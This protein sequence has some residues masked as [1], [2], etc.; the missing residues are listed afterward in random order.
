MEMYF[1]ST[2]GDISGLLPAKGKLAG[3]SIPYAP[4]P[5]EAVKRRKKEREGKLKGYIYRCAP[6]RTRETGERGSLNNA[7]RSEEPLA[8][9]GREEYI[10]E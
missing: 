4:T 3:Q 6:L 8:V 9:V 7:Y 5:R 10:E 1:F 2:R